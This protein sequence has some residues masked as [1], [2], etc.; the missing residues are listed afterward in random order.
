MSQR[1]M[2]LVVDDEEISRDLLKQIFEREYTVITAKDGKEA[3]IE[4]GRHINELS[5]IL[6]DLVMPVFNGYQVLQ[7]L[8]TKKIIERIPV[9]IFTAQYSAKVDISCY[10][11]GASAVIVKPYV[12]KVVELQVKNIIER[13]K[14][15]AMLESRIGGYEEELLQQ[16]KKL[17]E[18]YDKLLD[19][20]S[21]VVEFRDMASK[22]H[23][24]NVKGLTKIMT[25]NYRQLYPEAGLTDRR[26]EAIVRAS[27]VH[28][29]GKVAVPD[30]ILLKPSQL[31]EIEKEVM[32]SHTTRGCEILELLKDV[33]D[34]EQFQASYEIC[35]HH[36]ERY[37][38]KG[39]PDGL[40][41]DEIPISAAIVALV[42]TYEALISERVYKK[43]SDKETAYKKILEG[44][45]KAFS[46]Q[47]VRCFEYSRNAIEAYTDSLF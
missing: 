16:Q 4:I 17:D 28:D 29:I 19:A 35:R 24:R 39:Y 11:M 30:N 45:G 20:I 32:M 6:L 1:E 18:F 23:I 31:T 36:H 38:G 10:T 12:A 8:K 7:V 33:Q 40:K 46:P 44:E 43:R 37:D 9:V 27:V 25:E 22:S 26:A 42:D 3:I 41:G 34:Q 47:L 14:K 21:N 15:A 2:I 13:N 5:I